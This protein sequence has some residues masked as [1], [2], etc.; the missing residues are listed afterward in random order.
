MKGWQREWPV[1][2]NLCS[3]H[4]AALSTAIPDIAAQHLS[5]LQTYPCP[6]IYTLDHNNQ[7]SPY[8]SFNIWSVCTALSYLLLDIEL[9]KGKVLFAVCLCQN[10]QLVIWF[11]PD[12][13]ETY[14]S[15]VRCGV[16]SERNNIFI[17]CYLQEA[18]L[19]QIQ[20][21]KVSN[22]NKE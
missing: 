21:R 13:C 17:I 20:K 3:Q 1:M 11:L 5:Y 12:I 6:G 4:P 14:T 19:T 15:H 22:F 18:N 7:H 8:K 2:I 16:Y 10:F 9:M